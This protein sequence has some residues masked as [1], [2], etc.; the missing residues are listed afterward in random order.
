MVCETR[1][2]LRRLEAMLARVP[3]ERVSIGTVIDSL[4]AG[5]WGPCFLL[6]GLAALVPGIAPAFGIALCL[7]AAGMTLGQ[8]RPWLPDRLRRWHAGRGQLRAGLRRLQPILGWVEARLSP[9]SAIF[10]SWS[11]PSSLPWAPR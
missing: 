1:S 3:G 2:G 10:R 9:R 6:F 5:T 4:G 11:P 7:I 8:P